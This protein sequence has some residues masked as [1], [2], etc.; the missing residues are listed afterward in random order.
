MPTIT[1][2]KDKTPGL[3]RRLAGI[4]DIFVNFVI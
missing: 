4:E 2:V 1:W 3:E